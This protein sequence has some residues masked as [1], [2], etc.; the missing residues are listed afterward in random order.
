M[1]FLI[2]CGGGGES[3]VVGGTCDLMASPNEIVVAQPN[4]ACGGTACV[5]IT[6]SMPDLCTTQ[7]ETADE[8]VPVEGSL[9]NAGFECEPVLSIGPFACK[10]FCV[11][12]DRVPATSCP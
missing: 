4:A 10:K 2:A 6:S 9:C 12:A 1:V 3:P 8:C 11:C 7:C 5:H